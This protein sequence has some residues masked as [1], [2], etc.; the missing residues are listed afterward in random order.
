[1]GNTSM[2]IILAYVRAAFGEAS[3]AVDL[4]ALGMSDFNP[5]SFERESLWILLPFLSLLLVLYHLKQY[6]PLRRD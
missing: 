6:N 5:Y 4:A 2:R 3:D 1:M